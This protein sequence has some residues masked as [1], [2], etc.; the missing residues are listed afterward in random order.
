MLLAFALTLSLGLAAPALAHHKPDHDA[1]P[2][3]PDPQPEPQPEPEPQPD[4]QPQPQPEPEPEPPGHD[5]AG[6]G[7]SENAPGHDPNGPGNSEHAAGHRDGETEP[8]DAAEGRDP[9]PPPEEDEAPAPEERGGRPDE[10]RGEPASEGARGNPHEEDDT[11]GRQTDA[12]GRDE[13]RTRGKSDEA[14]GRDANKTRGASDEAPGRPAAAGTPASGRAIAGGGGVSAATAAPIERTALPEPASPRAKKAAIHVREGNRSVDVARHDVLVA[15]EGVEVP[16]RALL[17]VVHPN[18]TEE[19]LAEG[20]TEARWNTSTYENGYYTVEVRERSSSGEMTTLASTRVLVANPRAEALSAA[21]AVATGAAVSAGAGMLAARG[22]DITMI[23]KQAAFEA[24]GEAATR[25][26]EEKALAR[27]AAVARVDWRRRSLVLL[28]A[29]AGILG[30]F[31]AYADRDDV[32]LAL[33]IAFAAAFLYTVGDYG[34]EW[35][36]SRASGAHTRFRLWI[37]GAVSL[38]LSSL[39][40]RAPFGYPGYVSETDLAQAHEGARDLRRRAAVRALAF[41]GAGLALTL[42]FLLVGALWRWDV[43]EYGASVALMMGA[44]S[45]MPFRPMP[46]RD[47]WQWS[48]GAWFAAFALLVALYLLWQVALLPMG[49]L[50]ALGLAGGAGFVVALV[51]LRPARV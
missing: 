38:A 10:A 31:K 15:G 4:P 41:M 12:P 32:L 47:V 18:G 36:L 16:E 7:D 14:P 39:L 23:L 33:P 26:A 51:R 45:A 46:G 1:G 5:P 27:T 48:R 49:A 8:V 13:N 11:R 28:L 24:G 9:V 6:P 35:A 29:A 20:A 3:P 30:F 37:P 17:V 44:A 25:A 2:T 40:F 43:A 22:F 50:V 34:A 42:P 21:A 19:V